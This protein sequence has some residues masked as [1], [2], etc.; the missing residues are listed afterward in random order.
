M[1]FCNTNITLFSDICQF[2]CFKTS[3]GFSAAELHVRD[4]IETKEIRKVNAA[5]TMITHYGKAMAL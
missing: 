4:I 2:S 3:T 1:S 5:A